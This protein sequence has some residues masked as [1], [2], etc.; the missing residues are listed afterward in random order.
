MSQLNLRRKIAPISSSPSPPN[1]KQ[2]LR[3]P[4]KVMIVGSRTGELCVFTE[5]ARSSTESS[6]I[7]PALDLLMA[8]NE[9][10]NK[11]HINCICTRADPK[12]PN[13]PLQYI[14]KKGS[15]PFDWHTLVRILNDPIHNTSTNRMQYGEFL[16]KWLNM[17]S[18][19]I[20]KI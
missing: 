13:I 16:T 18:I 1:K 14:T 6:F 19:Y 10:K 12:N 3:F 7:Q 4:D 17:V 5:K 9:L 11:L 15:G 20:Y 8:N 2:A